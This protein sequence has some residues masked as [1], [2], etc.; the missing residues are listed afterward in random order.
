MVSCGSWFGVSY[1]QILSRVDLRL[2]LTTD[3]DLVTALN[4]EMPPVH[5][6]ESPSQLQNIVPKKGQGMSIKVVFLLPLE[7]V[8]TW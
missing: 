2:P 5:P 7:Q 3:C 6:S 8:E 4:K 1:V